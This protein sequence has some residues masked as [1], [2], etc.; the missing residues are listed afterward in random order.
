MI[1][2]YV[3]RFTLSSAALSSDRSV[4]AVLVP[5]SDSGICHGVMMWWSADMNGTELTMSPWQ[6]IQVCVC[7]CV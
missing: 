6:Y 4:P 7:V 5:V 2:Y 3:N 1:C